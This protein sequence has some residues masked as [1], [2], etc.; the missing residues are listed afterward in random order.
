[1]DNKYQVDEIDPS[2]FV[3][4]K[5]SYSVGIKTIDEEHKNL[6]RLINELQSAT[7]YHTGEEFEHRALAEL[8]D[9]TKFHFAREEELMKKFEFPG[10][11][12]HKRQHDEMAAKTQ[13]MVARYEQDNEL[14]VLN[15]ISIFLR[16]WLTNHISSTDKKYSEFLNFI[17]WKD[18][19]SVGIKTIDEEHKTLLRLINDLQSAMCY[20]TGEELERQA[21]AELIDYT[22]FH[23]AREEELMKKYEFPGYEDHKRQHDEMAAKTQKMVDRYEQED[24]LAVINEISIFLRDWLTNHINGID[25]KYSA[26]LISKGVR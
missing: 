4:W 26:Y 24:A 5:D 1:L 16:N 18:S 6:L 12:D 17:H 7:C 3:H 14:G 2:G 15:E 8:I 11:E 20:Y 9:Y 21:L 25:K 22:K 23:F 19:Y 10:Y 13:L